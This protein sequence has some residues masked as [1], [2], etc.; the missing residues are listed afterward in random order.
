[1]LQATQGTP[2]EQALHVW[3]APE[4][5]IVAVVSFWNQFG[6]GGLPVDVSLLKAAVGIGAIVVAV[7]PLAIAVDPFA[8]GLAVV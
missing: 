2:T 5:Q 7:P 6:G 1:M 4:L 3:S 8:A